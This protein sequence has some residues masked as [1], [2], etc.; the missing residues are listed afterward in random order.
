MVPSLLGRAFTSE[1]PDDPLD[2]KKIKPWDPSMCFDDQTWNRVFTHRL[3]TLI[4]ALTKSSM[5]STM[6]LHN[7]ET[8]HSSSWY[9]KK[10][11]IDTTH[12]WNFP[13]D[14]HECISYKFD[15]YIL[16]TPSV[17]IVYRKY[18]SSSIGYSFVQMICSAFRTVTDVGVYP[19]E[20][21][22]ARSNGRVKI[23][24]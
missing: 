17:K 19:M 23:L 3:K 5:R 9:M 21:H 13:F 12:W 14:A 4:H 20:H 1:M 8:A 16:M 15:V 24:D 18:S 22:Q 10:S 6:S 2:K 7:I 11:Q